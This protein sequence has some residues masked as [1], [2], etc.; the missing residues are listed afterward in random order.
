MLTID[1]DAQHARFINT[2]RRRPENSGRGRPDQLDIV[3]LVPRHHDGF[4][5]A[6][7][8]RSTGGSGALYHRLTVAGQ[9][10]APA[11]LVFST[12]RL[13]V[14]ARAPS[15]DC[16]CPRCRWRTAARSGTA[17]GIS[18]ASHYQRWYRLRPL[19][20]VMPLS[21]GAIRIVPIIR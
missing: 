17:W 15:A 14:G 16:C 4:I 10:G 7:V 21:C 12:W 13:P 6:T 9:G 3:E 20:V 1:F 5:S 2:F 19:R 11:E 18:G 8:H